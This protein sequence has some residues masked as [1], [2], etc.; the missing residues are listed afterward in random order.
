MTDPLFTLEHDGCSHAVHV[1]DARALPLADESVHLIVT[2]PPYFDLIEYP[3]TPGQLGNMDSYGRFLEQLEQAWA[4]CHRVLV[5]GGRVCCVVGD[6]LVSRRRGG[7]H[8]SIPLVAHT[9]VSALQVG[10]DNLTP[11]RW[12]K[13]TNAATETSDSA[14]FLGTPNQPNGIVKNDIETILFL[15][16]PG[17]YRSPTSV[18]ERASWIDNNEYAR[19]FRPVW[20]DVRGEQR[21]NHPAPFPVE[22]A[23]RLVRMFSYAGDVVL[24]PFAG[25]GTVAEA[26]METR[27]HSVSVE[28]VEDYAQ[29]ITRRLRGHYE[30]GDLF[31]ERS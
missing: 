16:K 4:E 9:Q 10:F 1:G 5:P 6:V 24:D 26:A 3:C 27:R 28:I 25:T 21:T 17:G 30:Q 7:R 12:L 19:W 15:R 31:M 11:I 13:I 2:S 8:Y 14:R 22:L 20:D 29:S 18:Q 23:R